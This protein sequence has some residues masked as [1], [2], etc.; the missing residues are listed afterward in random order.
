VFYFVFYSVSKTP[1]TIT[2]EM[3]RAIFTKP[4]PSDT[5]SFLTRLITS[6]RL[7][8]RGNFRKGVTFAGVTGRAEF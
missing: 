2:P 3:L 7:V 8:V 1:V 5:R 6:L 4:R